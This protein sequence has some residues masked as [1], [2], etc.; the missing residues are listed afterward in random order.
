MSFNE[1]ID[2]K[3]SIAIGKIA[4]FFG[5]RY[6]AYTIERIFNTLGIVDL[7]KGNKAE[8]ISYVLRNFYAKDKTLFVASL[9]ELIE[10]HQL[11]PAD[12]QKL[13]TSVV[14]LGFDIEDKKIV[15]SLSK[16]I[17][18]SEGKPYDAFKIIEGILTSAKRRIHIIDPYVDHSLFTLYLDCVDK[19]VEIKILTKKMYEKFEE[20]ARKFKAQRGSFEVRLSGNIHD[21]QILVDDRAWLFGQSLKNAGEKPL[22][23]IEYTDPSLVDKIFAEIWSK[24]KPFI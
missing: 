19:N 2:P 8:K 17:A 23:I 7:P 5:S 6:G 20:V 14:N 4:S 1:A 15:Q 21:R 9:E 16:E 11:N 12:I 22:N 3:K 18:T 24:A 13:R 10:N